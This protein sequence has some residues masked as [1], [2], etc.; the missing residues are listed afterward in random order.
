MTLV[1]VIVAMAIVFIV[2][3]G[4]SSAGLSCSTRT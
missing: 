1:E 2:F 4:M 3:L